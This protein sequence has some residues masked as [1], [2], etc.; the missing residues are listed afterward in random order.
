VVVSR[1][2]GHWRGTHPYFETRSELDRRRFARFVESANDVIPSSII[3]T[4]R[5]D[6]GVVV[7]PCIVAR[8]DP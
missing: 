2:V 3:M 8:I 4:A 5:G 1:D 7:H 6:P